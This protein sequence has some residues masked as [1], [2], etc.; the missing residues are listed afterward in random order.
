MVT[1]G[2]CRNGRWC[3]TSTLK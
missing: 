1:M 3:K 2:W